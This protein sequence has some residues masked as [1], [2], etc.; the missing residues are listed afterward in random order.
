M[1]ADAINRRIVTNFISTTNKYHDVNKLWNIED[2]GVDSKKITFFQSDKKPSSLWDEKHYVEHEHVMSSIPWKQLDD[3]FPNNNMLATS[4]LIPPIMSQE[5]KNE[6]SIYMIPRSNHSSRMTIWNLF[7]IFR[8]SHN[9]NYATF[10]MIVFPYKTD[11]IRLLFECASRYQG[12]SIIDRCHQEPDRRNTLSSIC[13]E[14][15][16]HPYIVPGDTEAMYKQMLVHLEDKDIFRLLWF[17]VE[18]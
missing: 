5:K 1:R 10:L 6:Y 17:N 13:L 14:F 9:K 4:R 8:Y 16:E 15:R 3:P 12:S 18:T 2:D 11:K 7:L